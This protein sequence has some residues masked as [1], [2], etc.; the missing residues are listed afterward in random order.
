MNYG[1]TN[2]RAFLLRRDDFGDEESAR[3]TPGYLAEMPGEPSTY[4]MVVLHLKDFLGVTRAVL[5]TL[6]EDSDFQVDFLT[7]LASPE[8]R[9]KILCTLVKLT[10]HFVLLFV[11]CCFGVRKGLLPTPT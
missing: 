8:Y 6:F 9:G 3:V 5:V 7:S 1:T 2:E 11:W 4:E 10:R